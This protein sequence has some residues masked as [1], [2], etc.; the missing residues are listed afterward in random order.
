MHRSVGN[1]QSRTSNEIKIEIESQLGFFPPFFEPA[2]G[3]PVI[4]EN[5]W[6]QTLNGY[7]RNPLPELFK[8]NLAAC[9][10]RNC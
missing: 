1:L 2:L 10:A 8:E 3:L 6:Q 5:L 9:L 4:L 7:I